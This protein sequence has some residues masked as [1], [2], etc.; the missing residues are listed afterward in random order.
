MRCNPSSVHVGE[1]FT[2][3]SLVDSWDGCKCWITLVSFH[4]ACLNTNK[5]GQNSRKIDKSEDQSLSCWLHKDANLSQLLQVPNLSWELQIPRSNQTLTNLSSN[6]HCKAFLSTSLSRTRL[7]Q[8]SSVKLPQIAEVAPDLL[9]GDVQ[10]VSRA[11]QLR[12]GRASCRG[13]GRPRG[14]GGPATREIHRHNV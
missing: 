2:F 12:V 11:A 14:V 4:T 6:Q 10:H 7:F 9:P 5:V 3:V 1:M 8:S 13:V